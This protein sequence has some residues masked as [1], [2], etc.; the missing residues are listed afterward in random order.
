M[1]KKISV[2]ESMAVLFILL[3]ILGILIIGF[4]LSPHIP[5]LIAFMCLLFY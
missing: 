1:N 4:Q 2:K 5:I 3:A